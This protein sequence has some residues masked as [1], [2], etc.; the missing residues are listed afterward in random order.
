MDIQSRVTEVTAQLESYQSRL[1]T[2]DSLIAYSTVTL[3]IYEVE[4]VQIVEELTVWEEIGQT[5]SNNLEDIGDGF[6]GFFVWF[7]GALPYLLLFAIPVCVV[8]FIIIRRCRRRRKAD[9]E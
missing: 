9:K 5:L 7:V 1:R 8:L 3:N 4:R 6:V 2:Y